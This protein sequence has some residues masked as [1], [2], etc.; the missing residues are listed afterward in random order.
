MHAQATPHLEA[1]AR[2]NARVAPAFSVIEL[3]VVIAIIALL[4]SISIVGLSVAR[5]AARGAVDQSTARAIKTG[6]VQ[7]ENDFGFVPPL[8]KDVSVTSNTPV[9]G[10][11]EANRYDSQVFQNEHPLDDEDRPVTFSTSL[12]NREATDRD[13]LRGWSSGGGRLRSHNMGAAAD[14]RFSDYSIAY[15]LAGALPASVDGVDGPGTTKVTARGGFA[16]VQTFGPYLAV[17][18]TGLEL[19]EVDRTQGRYELR[20]RTGTPIRY[21]RW[22]QGREGETKKLFDDNDELTQ[23]NIPDVVGGA[24]TEFESEDSDRVV[25]VDNTRL[26]GAEWAI[27]LPGS[28]GVFGDL[29]TE[30]AERLAN[31]TGGSLGSPAALEADAREDNVLEVGP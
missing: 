7:F 6:I 13:Y 29:A 30:G 31:A 1:P 20:T 10:R 4:I 16:G 28:D 26:R 21:Y 25:R 15:Y 27:V 12:A 18:Q 2:A 3:L 23:L 14:M 8:V 9:A 11:Y 22:L 17:G 5:Q 24:N 19:V